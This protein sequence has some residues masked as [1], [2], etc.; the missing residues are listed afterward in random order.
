[1]KNWIYYKNKK[2][3]INQLQNTMH[4]LVGKCKK[5][6]MKKIMKMNKTEKKEK[7]K[8]PAILWIK[9]KDN[10]NHKKMKYNFVWDEC[11]L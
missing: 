10:P 11:N 5:M 7:R 6:L 3:N 8:L 2:F 4:K 1:M 9:L